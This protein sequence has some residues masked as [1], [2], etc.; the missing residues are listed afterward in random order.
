MQFSAVALFAAAAALV[1]ADTI[2]ATESH[3]TLV[4]ITDCDSTVTDCPAKSTEAP[5]SSSSNSTSPV[6]VSTAEGAGHKQH[7]AAGV[8]ALAAGALLAL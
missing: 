5:V 2:T 6:P 1:S 8:A 4:T 3:S 7:A